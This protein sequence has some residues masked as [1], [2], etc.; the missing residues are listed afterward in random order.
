MAEMFCAVL[1]ALSTISRFCS[2][3]SSRFAGPET[4]SAAMASPFM[5]KIGAATQH[6]PRS[7]SPWSNANPCRWI[8]ASSEQET[9]DGRNGVLSVP[10]EL[11]SLKVLLDDVGSY[12]RQQCL[13]DARAIRRGT[14]AHAGT[15]QSDWLEAFKF[16]DV[17]DFHLVKNC[18]VHGFPCFVAQPV[19][20]GQCRVRRTSFP[21]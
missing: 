10:A 6:T 5:S 15:H 8:N 1:V 19:Q 16:L 4:L 11:S 21:L 17:N 12:I 13:A 3:G 7:C 20:L 2:I 14:A 9:S 18:Q